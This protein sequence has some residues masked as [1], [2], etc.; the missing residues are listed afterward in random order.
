[1]KTKATPAPAHRE[2]TPPGPPK[3]GN[4]TSDQ[5]DG[6]TGKTDPNTDPRAERGGANEH[7]GA[8]EDEVGDRTGPGAGYDQEP[9]QERDR[10]GVI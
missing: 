1:M 7:E 5:A 10:G 3:G 6:A 2:S 4:T 8:T 9:K